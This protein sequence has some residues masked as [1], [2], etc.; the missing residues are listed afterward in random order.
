MSWGRGGIYEFRRV[1]EWAP[2]FLLW[3]YIEWQHRIGSFTTTALLQSP[4]MACGPCV[5][6][7]CWPFTYFLP[8]SFS[9]LLSSYAGLLL[10]SRWYTFLPDGPF[11]VAQCPFSTL[12]YWLH[13]LLQVA[14]WTWPP[15]RGLARSPYLKCSPFHYS[16]PQPPYLTSVVLSPVFN[17]FICLFTCLL[18]TLIHVCVRHSVTSDSLWSH[19]LVARQAS[20]SMEFSRQEYWSGLPFPYPGIEPW[21]PADALPPEL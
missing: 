20:L 14:T 13:L 6:R 12:S 7:S 10:L 4:P 15:R 9:T 21:S 11:S 5:A 8:L 17:Y 1:S 2:G 3:V 19:E 18:P 16:L